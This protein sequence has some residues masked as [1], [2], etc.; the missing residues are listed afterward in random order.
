MS[1]PLSALCFAES[2]FAKTMWVSRNQAETQLIETT[3][4]LLKRGVHHLAS[5]IKVY[6]TDYLIKAI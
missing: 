4:G 3:E 1:K 6:H 2:P 5:S